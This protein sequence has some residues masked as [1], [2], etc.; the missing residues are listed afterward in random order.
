[1]TC[2]VVRLLALGREWQRAALHRHAR[3]RVEGIGL[4]EEAL[5]GR[6]QIGWRRAL[7]LLPEG[8]RLARRIPERR[9]WN[10]KKRP[11]RYVLDDHPFGGQE[12]RNF[13][14]DQRSR[15]ARARDGGQDVRRGVR[16]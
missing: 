7:V 4:N 3:R 2:R 8:P 11:E 10:G 16:R 9:E 13:R 5:K 15:A 6:Q 1:M 12:S 14:L